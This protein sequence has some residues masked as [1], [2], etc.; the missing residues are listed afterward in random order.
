VAF[1]RTQAPILWGGV[2]TKLI[3]S[4][5]EVISDPFTLPAN[6]ILL[7]IQFSATN[8]GTPVS[9]DTALF[10][11]RWSADGTTFD[12]AKGAQQVSFL[13][14]FSTYGENPIRRTVTLEPVASKL[15]FAVSCPLAASRN[16]TVVVYL[17]YQL[18]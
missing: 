9:G 4:A 12:T 17:D 10:K 11:V 3:T 16:I 18:A 6:C 5:T 7:G 1:S 2:G 13:D 15:Q 14:T 8:A